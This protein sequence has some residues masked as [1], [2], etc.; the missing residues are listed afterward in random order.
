MKADASYQ[1]V[2]ALVLGASGFIG[3]WV[4]RGLTAQGAECVCA[5]RDAH[6]GKRVLEAW[7][8]RATLE[9]Q[10]LMAPGAIDTLIR[11]VRPAIVFNLAGYGV[12]RT[13]QDAHLAQAINVTL[14]E[15]LGEALG[16]SLLPAWDGL[17]LV[18]AGTGAEYG[19]R[20][21][22]LRE[23]SAC[24]PL[25]LYGRTKH[26]GTVAMSRLRARLG[27]RAITARPFTLFGPGEHQG[28][29]L[30]SILEASRKGA[31]LSLTAGTQRRDFTY[32]EDVAE[33]MVR[34]GALTQ[35][36]PDVVNLG[37]GRLVTV[38]HFAETAAATLGMPAEQLEFGAQAMRRG[39]E[40]E[41]RPPSMARLASLLGWVPSTTIREGVA[42]TAASHRSLTERRRFS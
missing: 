10:D 24:L 4:A 12:D 23:D 35:P 13:E 14:V 6:A 26:E 39:E 32:V 36:V 40:V 9:E 1:G 5:V 42:R 33:G 7:G 3:R 18:H 31:V 37:T 22:D 21:D 30:Q 15:R 34:L 28:R 2:P 29:L 16:R 17:R 27:M 19:A 11:R 41:T 38:R 25:T 20:A 8:V